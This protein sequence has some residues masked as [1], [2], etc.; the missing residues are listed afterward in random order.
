MQA[1]ATVAARRPEQPTTRLFGTK[2]SLPAMALQGR[3]HVWCGARRQPNAQQIGRAFHLVLVMHGGL[4]AIAAA[5]MRWTAQ[6]ARTQWRIF[7]CIEMGTMS[8]GN[9]SI[10]RGTYFPVHFPPQS[11]GAGAPPDQL[12]HELP[13]SR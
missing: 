1:R 3:G 2:L 10:V 6:L 7:F 4:G 8:N 12:M 9:N 11:V 13:S 5:S